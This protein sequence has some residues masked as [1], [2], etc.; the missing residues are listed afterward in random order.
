MQVF[1]PC[2]AIIA[3]LSALKQSVAVI[4]DDMIYFHVHEVS[5]LG[6]FCG[7]LYSPAAIVCA[8]PV[9]LR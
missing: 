3:I 9:A 6:L 1:A 2:F 5:T 4:D 7:M 8:M